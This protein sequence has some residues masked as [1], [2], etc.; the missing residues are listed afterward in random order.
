MESGSA[1]NTVGVAP[2][3]TN[4][5]NSTSTVLAGTGTAAT[6][7]INPP[8]SKKRT[9]DERDAQRTRATLETLCKEAW[10]GASIVDF[11]D[12]KNADGEYGDGDSGGY[13]CIK[14]FATIELA[15]IRRIMEHTRKEVY[16]RNTDH[17]IMTIQFKDETDPTALRNMQRLLDHHTKG[18]KKTESMD[19]IRSDMDKLRCS[20]VCEFMANV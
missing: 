17:G 20:K 11:G 16:I 13:I 3:R 10:L 18:P 15:L 5:M 19:K 14:R 2:P 1:S 8:P 12:G 9:R 6:P 7:A 4:H